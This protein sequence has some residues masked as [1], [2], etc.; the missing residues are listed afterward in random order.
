MSYL[1]DSVFCLLF[2]IPGITPESSIALASNELDV[3]LSRPRITSDQSPV[4]E[5]EAYWYYAGL[6]SSPRLVARS[7]TPTTPWKEP[8]GPEAYPVR[9][10]LKGVGNHALNDVW[11]DKLAPLIL[12]ILE[13]ERVK[14]T[15]V[16]VVRIG[17]VGE[18]CPPV[19]LWI[20]VLP[21]SLTP[22]DGLDVA[23]QCKELLEKND[24][25]D[26]D[27]E[28]RESI[29]IRSAGPRFLDPLG[30]A[31]DSDPTVELHMPL[32]AAL[33]LSICAQSTPWVEGTGGFYMAKGG[34]SERILLITA[35]HVVF[36][37]IIVNNNRYEH[38]NPSQ[39]RRNV[40]LIGDGAFKKL[41]T[42]VQSEIRNAA[43][44]A[45]YQQQRLESL[46]ERLGEG[47]AHEMALK[48]AQT[49]LDKAKEAMKE[50][51][52]YCREV[53]EYWGPAEERV[54]GHVLYAP[55]IGVGATADQ[56]TEDFAVIAL[57]PCKIDAQN[58]KG[59]VID[60]GSKLRIGDFYD[61]LNV[62]FM[63]PLD[64]LLPLQGTILTAELR[65]PSIVDQNGE[66]CLM[67]L[68]RGNS[69]DLTIGRGNNV[70]S[71]VRHY[72]KDKEPQTSKEWPVLPYDQQS[73]A[74]S[75]QGDSG[76]VI[77]D[78]GG[79]IGGLITGGCGDTDDLDITYA[80]PMEFL[81]QRIAKQ[82]PNAHLIPG[83]TA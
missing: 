9:K 58:F 34:D 73:G 45:K 44:T 43:S 7:S 56:H 1:T 17:A 21:E 11:E 75:G 67:V 39:P 24:I 53:L 83:L 38:E 2:S 47:E 41:L 18:R 20:G 59:N 28:L 68:K 64:R 13:S 79:R 8:T 50:H 27:V 61:R 22:V 46:I 54:L 23:L 4:S 55:P 29:V 77:V 74:F 76:A 31:P 69:T 37:P 26:I 5:K 72:F 35:R 10:E 52:L 36:P 30:W 12:D 65:R 6:P 63:Y 48:E 25:A 60:L 3:Q 51:P 71:F 62:N 57:E 70:F 78:G 19:I 14:F 33:G 16:D 82:F 80:T 81:L 15:S 40:L 42:S 49:V 32:T 66:P